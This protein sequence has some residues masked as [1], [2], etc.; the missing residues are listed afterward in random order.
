MCFKN[1]NFQS[2]WP[3]RLV[4]AAARC[5]REDALRSAA[6]A[7]PAPALG[8]VVTS[9]EGFAFQP[10]APPEGAW[11][12]LSPG[13]GAGH[14]PPGPAQTGARGSL[15]NGP[16]TCPSGGSGAAPG[17]SASVLHTRTHTQE[18]TCA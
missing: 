17:R 5:E 8:A 6:W 16:L 1:S 3:A 7:S 11:L 15:Q 9:Q 12:G 2:L 13:A 14:R 4:T 18:H 10:S